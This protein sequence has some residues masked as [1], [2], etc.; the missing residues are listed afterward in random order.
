MTPA[1]QRFFGQISSAYQASP[2]ELIIVTIFVV[3]L[4][5]GLIAYAV[6]RSRRET[7]QRE[8]LSSNLYEEKA[9][10]LDLQPS[11]RELISFM[12][13]YLRDPSQIHQL[14]TDPVAFNSAAAK[15]RENNEANAQTIAALRVKLGFHARNDASAPRS[16]TEIREGAVV[17]IARNKYKKPFKAR[18][19]P[20]RPDSFAVRILQEG[21]RLPSG[22]GVDVFLQSPAGVFTFHTLVLAEE[23]RT[24]RLQHSEELKQYQKRRYY[25]RRIEVPVHLY[26]FDADKELLSKTRDIG[27][28]GASLLNP[29]GY[30]KS[31]D[32]IEVRFQ[33]DA[34]TI[35]VTGSVVRVSDGG[36]TIHVNYEHIRDPLRDRI[37]NAIFKPPKD[38]LDEMERAGRSQRPHPGQGAKTNE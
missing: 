30:F 26:P 19:L 17:L 6:I 12:A 21:A 11:H 33:T 10:E 4:V 8:N 38:E 36:R 2:V 28:G 22:A 27:G 7:E 1:V 35:K 31:G 32:D 34:G 24:A 23:G 3:G 13:R 29:D 18:V 16:S 15:V 9:K 37:Y 14:V 5:S 25:R 20:Q